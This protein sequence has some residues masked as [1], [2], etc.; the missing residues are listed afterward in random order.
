MSYGAIR[1]VVISMPA[2]TNIYDYYCIS[3]FDD[4]IFAQ[5]TFSPSYRKE[6]GNSLQP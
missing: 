4:Q 6:I 3:S 2:T 5:F 1:K